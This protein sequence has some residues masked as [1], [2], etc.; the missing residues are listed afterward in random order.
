[1]ISI[2]CFACAAC[3]A[4]NGSEGWGWFV[5]AGILAL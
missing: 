3:L 4:S 2:F 1:M 5:F